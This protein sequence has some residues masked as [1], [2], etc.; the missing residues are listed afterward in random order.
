MDTIDHRMRWLAVLGLSLLTAAGCYEPDEGSYTESTGSAGGGSSRGRQDRGRG[1]GH[2]SV[3]RYDYVDAGGGDV[4]KVEKQ[5]WEYELEYRDLAVSPDG[6]YLLIGAPLPGPN[7]GFDKAGLGLAAYDLE[8]DQ[9]MLVPGLV[10]AR[11]VNFRK[12]GGRV[13]VL[14]DDGKRLVALHGSDLTTADVV[15]LS[16]PARSIDVSPDGRYV[17]LSNT[18][19]G[20]Q[21]YLNG[22]QML[23][24]DCEVMQQYDGMYETVDRCDFQI[25]D[26]E[27]GKLVAGRTARGI[28][29]LDFDSASDAVIFTTFEP[30][31]DVEVPPTTRLRFVGLDDA[32]VEATVEVP[33]CGDELKI[34]AGADLALLSP[35]NCFVLVEGQTVDPISFVDLKK[36]TF[37][38][39]IPGFG[40]VEVSAD[41]K[42]AWGFTRKEVMLSDW[43][44]EQDTEFGLIEVD[45][46]SRS[47]KVHD[48]A[49][50]EPSYTLS[51][52]GAHLLVWERGSAGSGFSWISREGDTSGEG[53]TVDGGLPASPGYD[54]HLSVLD[55]KTGALA[56]IGGSNLRPMRFAWR[57]GALIFTAPGSHRRCEAWV[58]GKWTSDARGPVAWE[59]D[60]GK[61]KA[62]LREL[63]V[64][65]DFLHGVATRPNGETLLGF[66][67]VPGFVRLDASC[68]VA[69]AEIIEV[70]AFTPHPQQ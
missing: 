61:G 39:N 11:R 14:T 40:P 48:W 60:P 16:K 45:I 69:G 49:H 51:P 35:R 20:P 57:K 31:T 65:K 46:A 17:V 29:D 67:E 30:T 25:Y 50:T 42:T 7:K 3:E 41:G 6:H 56:E 47:W 10:D 27:T 24:E 13:Y 4:A 23:S 64:G 12:D 34:V 52:D 8:T 59:L 21:S 33:N 5:S 37:L 36:R 62:G 66:E 54:R 68:K 9:L 22:A 53:C 44:Y 58:D 63:P 26:D 32:K 43:G 2:A 19:G 15:W 70:D 38:E 18:G 28:L 55:T 1:T